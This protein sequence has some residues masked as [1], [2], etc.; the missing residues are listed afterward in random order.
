MHGLSAS[1]EVRHAPLADFRLGD[2]EFAWYTPGSFSDLGEIDLLIVDGPPKV[3]GR[4]ARYPA[5]PVFLDHL[6]DGALVV[7]DDT[8]RATEQ[9]IVERWLEGTPGLRREP[10]IVGDQAVLRYSRPGGVA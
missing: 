6:A 5:L 1:I 7:L 10:T 2:E 9:K 8:D 3:T 4:L